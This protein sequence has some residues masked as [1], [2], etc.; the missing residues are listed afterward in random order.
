MIQDTHVV[1]PAISDTKVD[2]IRW[3]VLPSS[4]KV[5]FGYV[6]DWRN[7]SGGSYNSFYSTANYC[8]FFGDQFARIG[9]TGN[10]VWCVFS[11]GESIKTD[12]LDASELSTESY[13]HLDMAQLP[14]G[15]HQVCTIVK[16][17][18]ASVPGTTKEYKRIYICLNPYDGI[19]G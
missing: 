4:V 17:S 3:S 11:R 10:T 9:R 7:L 2:S 19:P 14:I 12:E 1:L 6:P 13:E 18:S 15:Q 5:D 16:R 8:V